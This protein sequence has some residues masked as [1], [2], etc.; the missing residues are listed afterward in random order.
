MLLR[1]EQHELHPVHGNR[2][3]HCRDRN[4]S[5]CFLFRIEA[6]LVHSKGASLDRLCSCNGASARDV[7]KVRRNRVV[8]S[9]GWM[10]WPVVPA[11][12][13]WGRVRVSGKKGLVKSKIDKRIKFTR[14]SWTIEAQRN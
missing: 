7:G 10:G 1:S 8:L 9:L 4:S 3:D 14:G 13:F 11:T 5:V 2:F 6:V 12:R